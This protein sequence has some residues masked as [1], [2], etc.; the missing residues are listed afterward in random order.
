[1]IPFKYQTGSEIPDWRAETFW[2]KEPELLHW[3][4]L[5]LRQSSEVSSF[6]DVGANVGFY[7]LYAAFLSSSVEILSIEPMQHNYEALLQNLEL[8]PVFGGR[9]RAL[10]CALSSWNGWG[11]MNLSDHRVGSSGAQLT[12]VKL[13]AS[14]SKIAVQTLDSLLSDNRSFPP[15]EGKILIKVDTD[16]NELDVLLGGQISFKLTKVSS[17]LVETHPHNRVAI[18]ELLG[19]YGFTEDITYLDVENH[20]NHRRLLAGKPER[21]KIFSRE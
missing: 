8:N 10:H 17:I 5:N 21:T 15:G 7:S 14:Q 9:I 1:M 6:I 4:E 11:M 18:E 20:S 16:G 12:N 2:T 19:G 13:E 3:L